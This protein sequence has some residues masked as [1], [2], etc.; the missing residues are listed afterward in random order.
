MVTDEPVPYV[1]TCAGGCGRTML[2]HDPALTIM[3]N[4]CPECYE[5]EKNLDGDPTPL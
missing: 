5:K 1:V 3:G 2:T 4:T